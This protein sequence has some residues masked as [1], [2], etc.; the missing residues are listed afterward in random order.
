MGS[1]LEMLKSP[2]SCSS[3]LFSSAYD[4]ED[5]VALVASNCVDNSPSL[6]FFISMLPFTNS[7]C[8]ASRRPPSSA[9]SVFAFEPA[10]SSTSIRSLDSLLSSSSAA[11]SSSFSNINSSFCIDSLAP[12][13]TLLSTGVSSLSDTSSAIVASRSLLSVANSCRAIIPSAAEGTGAQSKLMRQSFVCSNGGEILSTRW[14]SH[15]R[16]TPRSMMKSVGAVVSPPDASG[17]SAEAEATVFSYVSFFGVSFFF[18]TTPFLT[19]F[20][21]A[22]RRNLTTSIKLLSRFPPGVTKKRSNVLALF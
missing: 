8:V 3:T 22:D 12:D 19:A 17:V 20:S 1:S 4:F 15:R 6:A 14:A 21:F 11:S 18:T 10:P 5:T 2:S 7:F 9:V 13:S 16:S